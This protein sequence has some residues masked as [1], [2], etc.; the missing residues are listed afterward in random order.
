MSSGEEKTTYF[1]KN[2]EGEAEAEYIFASLDSDAKPEEAERRRGEAI[3]KKEN[4]GESDSS[5]IRKTQ[6]QTLVARI[7]RREQNPDTSEAL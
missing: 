3:E 7:G 6:S 4:R 5:R 2:Q 1:E